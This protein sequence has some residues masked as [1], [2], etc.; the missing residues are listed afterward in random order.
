MS[1]NDKRQK[2]LFLCVFVLSVSRITV[3]IWDGGRGYIYISSTTK[4]SVV[5]VDVVKGAS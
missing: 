2:A 5:C 3:A 1:N 4:V